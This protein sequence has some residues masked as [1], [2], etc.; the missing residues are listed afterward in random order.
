LTTSPACL[1]TLIDLEARL[2]VVSLDAVPWRILQAWVTLGWEFERSETSVD[3]WLE[4]TRMTRLLALSH[5]LSLLSH[6]HGLASLGS[7]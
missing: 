3:H 1:Q 7:T 4:E 2:Y 6:C 5:S